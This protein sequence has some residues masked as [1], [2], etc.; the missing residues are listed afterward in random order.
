MEAGKR[1]KL[2]TMK[3]IQRYKAA[4]QYHGTEEGLNLCPRYLRIIE[5][6][7]YRGYDIKSCAAIIVVGRNV[8]YFYWSGTGDIDILQPLT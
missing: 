6:V 8:I 7:R 5:M 2:L 1:L 3:E 4:R